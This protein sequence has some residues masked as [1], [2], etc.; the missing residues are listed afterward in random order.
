M[1][2]LEFR[3]RYN[4]Q[5]H[6]NSGRIPARRWHKPAGYIRQKTCACHWETPRGIQRAARASCTCVDQRVEANSRSGARAWYLKSPL[7]ELR[8]GGL[9]KHRGAL[10]GTPGSVCPQAEP[11]ATELPSCAQRRRRRRRW[12]GEKGARRSGPEGQV[13][14]HVLWHVTSRTSAAFCAASFTCLSFMCHLRT[15][16]WGGTRAFGVGSGA[17][18]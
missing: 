9:Y 14:R 18:R 6:Q 12:R 17:G 3:Y 7:R 16:V 8:M 5:S 10:R 13:L 1:T 15:S 4:A 11:N 2:S